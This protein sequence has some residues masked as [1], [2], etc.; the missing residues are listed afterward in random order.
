[1]AFYR[2]FE[3]LNRGTFGDPKPE[4]K[5]KVKKKYVFKKKPTG[6]KNLFEEI[7]KT[8]GAYSQISGEYLGEFNICYFAHVIPKGKNKYPH[9]K[10]YAQNIILMTLQQH[11]NWDN[12]RHKC[13]GKEWDFM[14]ELESS[15][16]EQ[17]KLL[18]E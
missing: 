8:R 18:H 15:L 10:L 14:Y 1:M 12:A 17:Y 13:I 5:E 3:Q 7:W 9:F 11:H 6:E 4:K 16:K 2:T